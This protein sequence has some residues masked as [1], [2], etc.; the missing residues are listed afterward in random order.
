[1][2]EKQL[3]NS[4]YKL[5]ETGIFITGIFNGFV[6]WADYNNDGLLDFVIAGNT[7]T[8]F[9]TKIYKNTGNNFEET[10]ALLPSSKHAVWA[11]FDNDRLWDI[12]LTDENNNSTKVFKN[13]RNDDFLEVYSFSDNSF[14]SNQTF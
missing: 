5:I 1:M 2:W 12:L 11:D 8:D 6:E 13:Q 9:I 10:S 14:F 3:G 4:C 7:G